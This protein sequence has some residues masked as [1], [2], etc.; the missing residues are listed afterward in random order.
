MPR[1][2]S[3]HSRPEPRSEPTVRLP[4]KPPAI[5]PNGAPAAWRRLPGESSD[6]W[7]RRT[8]GIRPPEPADDDLMFP[9]GPVDVEVGS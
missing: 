4:E 7:H 2:A 3:S 8:E 9:D 6:D 5:G 1:S